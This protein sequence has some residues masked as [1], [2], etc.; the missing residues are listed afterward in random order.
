MA[1]G[2]PEALG[3]N[4]FNRNNF[5]CRKSSSKSGKSGTSSSRRKV[6]PGRSR[7]PL[8]FP[9]KNKKKEHFFGNAWFTDD[10]KGA[11]RR[12]LPIEVSAEGEE[13]GCVGRRQF[14][15]NCA[16]EGIQHS[17]LIG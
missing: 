15:V 4:A 11:F 12:F 7:P 3:R 16:T 10:R 5:V 13:F 8:G 2:D 17:D 14:E 6:W 9:R 1:G